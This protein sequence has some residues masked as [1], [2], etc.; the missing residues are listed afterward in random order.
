M[1]HGQGQVF[2]REVEHIEDDGF[3]ASVLAVVDG[4]DHLYDSLTL[5]DY[6]LLAILSDDGQ[7]ALH[8]YTVVH[9]GVVMPAQLL[10]S[11]EHVLHGHQLGASLEIVGQLHPIPALRGADEFCRLHFRF[12]SLGL[13]LLARDHPHA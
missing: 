3:R 7:L 8:Q 6:F 9:D 4:I 13:S 11:G 10:T 5:V 2:L 1:L 12:G